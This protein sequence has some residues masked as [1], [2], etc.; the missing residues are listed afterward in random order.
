VEEVLSVKRIR[1]TCIDSVFKG[2][3]YGNGLCYRIAIKMMTMSLR[4]IA[5]IYLYIIMRDPDCDVLLDLIFSEE[6]V[7]L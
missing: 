3:L 7:V 5:R 2:G 4:I 1:V 6:E